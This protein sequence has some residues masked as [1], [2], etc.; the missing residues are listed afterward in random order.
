MIGPQHDLLT[1]RGRV[2]KF[3]VATGAATVVRNESSL[4]S[5]AIPVR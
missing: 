5:G 2:I 3:L 1:S 4:W